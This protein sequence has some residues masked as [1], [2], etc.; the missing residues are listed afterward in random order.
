MIPHNKPYIN[1]NSY[2]IIKSVIKSGWI[3]YSTISHEVEDKLSN[4]LYQK[5]NKVNLVINGTSALF[6]ALK[7]L[8]IKTNDEVIIPSYT[9]TALLNA[10]NLIGA[11]A[12]IADVSRENL[13]FSVDLLQ[14]YISNKTKAII[15]VHTFGIP[16]ELGDIQK[17]KIPIIEDCSQALGSRFNDGSLV[18]SKGDISVFSFYATK[19]ITGGVGGAIASQNK[20]ILEFIQDYLNFDCP[21]TYKS[22]FNFQISDINS[23]MIL[24]SLNNLETV[25]KKK[26]KIANSYLKVISSQY[27]NIIGANHYR[28]LIEFNTKEALLSCQKYLISVGIKTIIPIENYELLHRYLNL[29]S[30]DYPNSEYLSKCILSIPI[31]VNLNKSEIKHIQRSLHDYFSSS[32]S[33]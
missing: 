8:N 19:L 10:I 24:A 25:L 22:R 27:A 18:G 29:N 6:L 15:L 1:K 31:F 4:L 17:F 3:N 16:C 32:A 30:D 5:S 12:I 26:R 13:S 14:Q 9:C 20:N 23:S 2:K 7:A 33:V 21:K 28:F 11:K